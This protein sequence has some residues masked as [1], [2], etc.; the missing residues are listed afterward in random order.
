MPS[1]IVDHSA[2]TLA[3]QTGFWIFVPAAVASAVGYGNSVTSAGIGIGG[4]TLISAV[5]LELAER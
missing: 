3:V 4:A 5:V 1:K 2:R